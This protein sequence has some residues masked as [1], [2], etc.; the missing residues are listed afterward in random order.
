MF[1]FERIIKKIC[2]NLVWEVICHLIVALSS[3]TGHIKDSCRVQ[4]DPPV[5]P[6]W[7]PGQ[8]AAQ[9]L[10]TSCS[11]CSGNT[12]YNHLVHLPVLNHFK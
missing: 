12:F 3:P 4:I 10:L 6:A 8:G 9:R 2:K 7:V 5:A 11:L 1:Y